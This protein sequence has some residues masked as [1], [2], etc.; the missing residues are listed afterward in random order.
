MDTTYTFMD[1]STIMT[2][3]VMNIFQSNFP[4]SIKHMLSSNNHNVNQ[5]KL[6]K[7]KGVKMVNNIS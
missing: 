2:D 3:S 7:M 5:P 4:P 6:K 1:F